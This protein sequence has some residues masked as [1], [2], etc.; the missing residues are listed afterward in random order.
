MLGQV[1]FGWTD[2]RCKQA[3]GSNDRVFGGKPLILTGDPGQ[4]PPVADKPLYHAKPSNAVGEQDYQTYHMFDKVV[5]PTVNQEV[6]GMTSEQYNLEIYCYDF[7]KVRQ[8]S[9]TGN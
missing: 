7:V 8:Q 1:T 3:T 5:K 6:Q 2:K 9:K 4:L